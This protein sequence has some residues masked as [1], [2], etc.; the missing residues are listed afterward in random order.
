MVQEALTNV[1]RHAQATEVAVTI[2]L[3]GDTMTVEVRDNGKGLGAPDPSRKSYGILG[4]RERAQTLGGRARIY[5][6][7]SGGTI[8]EMT[9]PVAR[10]RS[11]EDTR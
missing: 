11:A 10:Y 3:A 1:V 5:S 2:R 6:P 8:V 7:E 4:I 9:I